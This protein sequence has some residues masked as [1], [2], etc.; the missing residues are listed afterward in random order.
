MDPR[1]Q[2]RMGGTAGSRGISLLGHRY[3]DVDGNIVWCVCD[4]CKAFEARASAVLEH[5][6]KQ[7]K[8]TDY[9]I[10]IPPK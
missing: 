1:N 9:L 2:G 6:K 8:I 5:E 4:L 7:A 10:A 3:R